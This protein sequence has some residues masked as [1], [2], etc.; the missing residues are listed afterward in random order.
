MN[1]DGD[2]RT[3]E[4]ALEVKGARPDLNPTLLVTLILA[5]ARV[6]RLQ[7]ER[8]CCPEVCKGC[9]QRER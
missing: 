9:H 1:I 4:H 7:V 3:Q 8:V 6:A 5:S 2:H